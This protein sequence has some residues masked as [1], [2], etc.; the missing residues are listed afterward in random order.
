MA[1]P[2][3]KYAPVSGPWQKYQAPAPI[4]SIEPSAEE[5][6]AAP[7]ETAPKPNVLADSAASFAA[8]I[9]RGAVETVMLPETVNRLA[10]GATGYLFDR[11]EDAIRSAFGLA[12]RTDADRQKVRDLMHAQPT[13]SNAAA[14]AQDAI[15]SGM[16]DVLYEPRTTPG[17]FARTVGEF[18]TPGGIPSKSARAAPTLAA[19]AAEYAGDVM[20]GAVAPGLLSEGAGEALDGTPYEGAGRVAGAVLGNAG[21]G[22]AKSMVAPEMVLRRALGGDSVDWERARELQNNSTGIRLTG[23]EAIT[24]AQEGASAL[25]NLQRVVE[26]SV[27]GRAATAPFF[28]ERPQQVDTAVNRVLDLVAP[29]SEAPSML[30]P[31][32]SNAAEQAIAV[33][34]E[35]KALVDAIFGAGPRTT[36]MQAG[37]VIQPELRNVFDRREG[38][39]NALA[40]ADYQAARNA[41]AAVPVTDL[42]PVDTT[43]RPAFTRIEPQAATEDAPAQMTPRE[44]PAETQTPAMT[45]RTGGDMVQVDARPVVQFID[46][47]I[48]TARAG[49]QDALRSVRNMLFDSGGVDTGV[50]GLDSARGQIGDMITEARQGG[51]MQTADLLGQVQ[52]RLDQALETVPEYANARQGFQAASAPLEPFQSPGMA[53]TISR[54]E[55][56]R[57][58]ATPPENVADTLATPS[59][60]RN[61]NQVATPAARDAM[62][63]RVATKILDQ[64]TDGAGGVSAERLAAA[65]RANEDLL[66]QFP[67]VA[68]RLNAVMGAADNMSVARTGPVGRVAAAKDTT[69]AGNAIL[70][71]NPL[72]G[73]EKETADA[74][75]RL[76]EQDPEGTRSLVRQVM[77]DRYAK[78]T[79]E[80]QE[81]SREF[82]GAKFHKDMAGNA[83]R[84]ATLDAALGSLPDKAAAEAMPELLDVLQATGR[85]K[86]IGSATEFN[87]ALNADLGTASPVARA[88]DTVKTLGASFVTNAG[89]AMKRAAMRRSINKLADMFTDPNSVDLIREAVARGR[90]NVIPEVAARTALQ[91]L[92]IMTGSREKRAQ[93]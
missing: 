66:A 13:L 55:F 60:A 3:E 47:L 86:A 32:A 22:L 12:P 11:G 23:P 8:G 62:Q 46:D 36:A 78:A 29:Q 87:R 65:L 28:S 93:Q 92:P 72:V 51:Q 58:F 75:R 56:N 4:A 19:K 69:A 80:T 54:D 52:R 21:V 79:T 41:P 68:D 24:Q 77:G 91:T 85:R 42:E 17:K 74:V 7:Q 49:T 83:Q 39:R 35:G 84:R 16:N 37:E 31:R 43:T 30:G 5:P 70:P 40:D 82:A 34:P 9:P 71:Q 33:S 2:W 53:K 61:F 76:A 50:N 88:V 81:G 89:D 25:P 73:S 67:E 64:A 57:Q 38:M 45:S 20:R 10:E 15:R 6:P 18:V 14:D 48:P 26:G 90:V 59:E 1:G 27:E 44:I 63:N